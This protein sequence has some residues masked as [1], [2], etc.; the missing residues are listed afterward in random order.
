MNVWICF[1]LC[2][3]YVA[4]AVACCLCSHVVYVDGAAVCCLCSRYVTGAVA[5]CYWLSCTD[6]LYVLWVVCLKLRLGLGGNLMHTH[7]PFCKKL[8]GSCPYTFSSCPRAVFVTFFR[9]DRQ[10]YQVELTNVQAFVSL[11]VFL[12][13][14]LYD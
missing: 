13:L 1:S 6:L 2:S 14:I 12:F 9:G 10:R 7:P 4:V 8:I 11:C 3:R 5:C